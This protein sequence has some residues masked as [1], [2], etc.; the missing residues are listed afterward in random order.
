MHKANIPCVI[1]IYNATKGNGE[2]TIKGKFDVHIK[3]NFLK[4]ELHCV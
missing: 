4:I 2:V 1:I 3:N